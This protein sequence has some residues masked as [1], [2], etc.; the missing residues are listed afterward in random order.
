[1]APL[2]VISPDAEGL[3]FG[4]VQR[5]AIVHRAASLFELREV[6]EGRLGGAT[7]PFTLDLIGHST[8]GHQLLRLGQAVIDMLD[9][10]VAGFFQSI[11]HER[12]LPRLGIEAV[13]LLACGTAVTPAGRRTLRLLARTLG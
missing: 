10:A 5:C 12:L 4:P 8:R 1:V 3:F 9:A 7:P 2:I 11:A 6:L 13:R